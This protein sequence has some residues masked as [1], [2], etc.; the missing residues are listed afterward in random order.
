MQRSTTV[1]VNGKR[2]SVNMWVPEAP[3]GAAAP[4]KKKAKRGASGGAGGGAASGNVEAP[5][6]GT[7][8]KL[9][10]AVG[11]AVEIGAGIVVLEAMK[12]E[13]QINA[14]KAGT[15]KE[16]KVAAGDTVGGG[17]VLAIIE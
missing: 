4:S 8:V 7:I 14:E 15:V 12:M 9:L 13:N 3:A 2:F 17:D 5:M 6:Q 16:L 11:D 1:E 10:V